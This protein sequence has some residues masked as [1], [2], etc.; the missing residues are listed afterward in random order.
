LSSYISLAE[1]SLV[2]HHNV[3]I[4][5]TTNCLKWAKPASNLIIIYALATSHC[6]RSSESVDRSLVLTHTYLKAVIF[7]A[8]KELIISF[9]AVI[10]LC[11]NKRTD[12]EQGNYKM[13]HCIIKECS[14]TTYGGHNY[15]FTIKRELVIRVQPRVTA[16]TAGRK[17]TD[18]NYWSLR[19]SCYKGFVHFF[20]AYL[21]SNS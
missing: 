13:T 19:Y 21:R 6:N 11:E 16:T 2:Y 15:V 18:I 14:A 10:R 4:K 17:V 5:I 1:T 20:L 7:F 12:Q 8:K 9:K 3:L